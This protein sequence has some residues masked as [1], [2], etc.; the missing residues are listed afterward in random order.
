L[1]ESFAEQAMLLPRGKTSSAKVEAA[2]PIETDVCLD[3]FIMMIE[4]YDITAT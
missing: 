4:S 3:C 2:V 1:T